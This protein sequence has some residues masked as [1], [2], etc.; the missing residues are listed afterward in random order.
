MVGNRQ[1]EFPDDVIFGPDAELAPTEFSGS[2][3]DCSR[4]IAALIS[5]R[6]VDF[7]SKLFVI[8][9]ISELYN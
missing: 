4:S 9:T 5:F 2:G 6:F 7:G 1:I 3:G 8:V